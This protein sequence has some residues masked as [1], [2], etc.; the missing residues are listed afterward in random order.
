MAPK[1]PDSYKEEKRQTLLQ[2]AMQCFSDKGF[3]TTTIDDICRHAGVSKGMLYTYFESKEDIYLQLMEDTTAASMAQFEQLMAKCRTA[4]DKLQVMMERF[5]ELPQN[6]GTQQF[7]TVQFEFWLH[8]TRHQELQEMMH[9]RYYEHLNLLVDILKEGIAA[10]EFSQ[11]VD[12]EG[13]ASIV[14]A[15]RD[16]TSLHYLQLKS[17]S[18]YEKAYRTMEDMMYRYLGIK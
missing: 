2:S 1:V 7:Y 14:W 13:I 17:P 11:T 10:G 6:L 4:V 12:A 18:D 15:I 8:S 9:K 3:Q 16:G 5:R